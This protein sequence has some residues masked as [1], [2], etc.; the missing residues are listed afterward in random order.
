[1]N[2]DGTLYDKIINVT[3][4]SNNIQLPKKT[5]ITPSF[6]F[7][8]SINISGMIIAN[9]FFCNIELRIKNAFIDFDYAPYNSVSID[10]GYSGDLFYSGMSGQ[11]TQAYIETPGPDGVTVFMIK[12]TY[13]GILENYINFE[14]TGPGTF[15]QVLNKFVSDMN[16]ELSSIGIQSNYT[17]Y[18]PNELGIKQIQSNIHLSGSM[19]NVLV[20]IVE[21]YMQ[22]FWSV[23]AQSIVVFN[24]QFISSKNLFEINRVTSTPRSTA[25][26]HISFTSPWL[27]NLRPGDCIHINP[28]YLKASFGTFQALKNKGD[29]SEEKLS[30]SPGYFSIYSISFE[31]DTFESINTMIVDALNN[32]NIDINTGIASS[33]TTDSKQ[34]GKL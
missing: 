33:P 32:T 27:P 22:S 25:P 31:F 19:S 17:I 23:N 34:I 3:F 30:Y 20:K 14:F 8:P 1:M 15:N 29:N 2:I 5:L 4:F 6:G 12:I 26:G 16:S 24:K 11:I 7:R 28:I 13:Q 10:A 21:E 18:V 9:S